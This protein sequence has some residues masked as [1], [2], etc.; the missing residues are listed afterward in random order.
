MKQFKKCCEKTRSKALLTLLVLIGPLPDRSA[1]VSRSEVQI[2]LNKILEANNEE[3]MLKLLSSQEKE[4]LNYLSDL[5]ESN[6]WKDQV[7]GLEEI[8][9]D[10]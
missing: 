8:D 5:W 2:K 7:E 3:E 6:I 10:K 4:M 9:I 1:L